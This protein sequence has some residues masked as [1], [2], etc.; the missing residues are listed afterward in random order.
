M[1]RITYKQYYGTADRT[2]PHLANGITQNTLV[3]GGI[4]Q[5]DQSWVHVRDGYQIITVTV[6]REFESVWRYLHKFHP[7]VAKYLHDYNAHQGAWGWYLS[8][9]PWEGKQILQLQVKG[10]TPF[11][12][13]LPSSSLTMPYKTRMQKRIA[14]K[15]V[16][17]MLQT[18]VDIQEQGKK[19]K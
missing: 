8:I 13:G 18:Y 1:R 6:P 3:D 2:V 17:S 10:P 12:H 15:F 9:L 14:L 16:V 11:M 19:R 5:R 4:I 7:I